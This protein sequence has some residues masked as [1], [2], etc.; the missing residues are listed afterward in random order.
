ME[1]LISCIIVERN[2]V[3]GYI[4]SPPDPPTI[5]R[6]ANIYY[7]NKMEIFWTLK[8][9]LKQNLSHHVEWIV[10]FVWDISYETKTYAQVAGGMMHINQEIVLDA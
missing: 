4:P 3:T 9:E 8:Q 1:H 5:L 7:L 10:R 2:I 6:R